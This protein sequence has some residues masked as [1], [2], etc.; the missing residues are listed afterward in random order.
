MFI[1]VAFSQE[2]KELLSRF[3][4]QFSHSPATAFTVSEPLL[5]FLFIC[6]A[7]PVVFEAGIFYM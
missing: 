1:F 4:L 6:S 2:A 5:D 3:V 7:D